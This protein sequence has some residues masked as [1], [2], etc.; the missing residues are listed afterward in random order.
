MSDIECFFPT[1]PD[2]G[3]DPAWKCIKIAWN[4]PRK[5]RIT[6]MQP[7]TTSMKPGRHQKAQNTTSRMLET[8]S[9]MPGAAH[10]TFKV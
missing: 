5:P 7:Q 9:R 3:Q 1:P 8:T 10:A 4:M 6:S 2:E